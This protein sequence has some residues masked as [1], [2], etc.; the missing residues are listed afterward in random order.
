M[1]LSSILAR[2]QPKERV[3]DIISVCYSFIT[4]RSRTAFKLSAW[5]NKCIPSQEATPKAKGEDEESCSEDES[6]A[7]EENQTVCISDRHR[8]R[9]KQRITKKG[10]GRDWVLK[11]KEQMRKKGNHVPPDT[12]YTARK[13]KARF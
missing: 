9:K 12:K 10:K 4:K 8:P 2:T 1:T 5:S 6:S 3:K 11:K 7:D 13:R